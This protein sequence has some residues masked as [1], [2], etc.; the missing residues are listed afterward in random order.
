MRAVS[1]LAHIPSDLRLDDRPLKPRQNILPLFKTKRS[2]RLAA[3][4]T[5]GSCGFSMGFPI[6][7]NQ[8]P[9]D[10]VS[11]SPPAIPDSRISRIRF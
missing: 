7:L 4:A 2:G 6:V 5:L 8:A 9:M 3:R 11:A 1:V 10:H